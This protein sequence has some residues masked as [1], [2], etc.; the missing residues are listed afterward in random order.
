MIVKHM[1]K[2]S[3]MCTYANATT[4]GH[5]ARHAKAFQ[6]CLDERLGSS[7]RAKITK[8]FHKHKSFVMCVM[9]PIQGLSLH[10]FITFGT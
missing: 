5:V 4:H 7:L 10:I 1:Q 9:R 6:A 3:L 2:A 8:H